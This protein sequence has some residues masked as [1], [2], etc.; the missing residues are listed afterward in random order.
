MKDSFQMK[1]L[2]QTSK[3]ISQSRKAGKNAIQKCTARS[4]N[5]ELSR[6]DDNI[7]R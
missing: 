6:F 5:S 1:L 2:S 7:G 4:G 3:R